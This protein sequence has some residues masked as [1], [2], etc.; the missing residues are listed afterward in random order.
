MR[1]HPAI[2]PKYLSTTTDQK[3]IV[4]GIRIA[5]KIARQSPVAEVISDEYSPG[6]ELSDDDYD[7]I[8][9]WA[10]NTA[11][12]IYHPTGTCKMGDDPMAVVDPRLR[13]HGIDNLRVA[14]ASIMPTLVSGNTNAPCIMIGEKASD[15]IMEDAARPKVPVKTFKSQP[16]EVS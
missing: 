5:R 2:H 1:D 16:A 8:L 14:D 3:T 7:G 6:W 10:R 15:L 12:T 9:D 13:V 4:A 11:T